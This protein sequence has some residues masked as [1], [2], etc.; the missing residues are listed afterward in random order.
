MF[1]DSAFALRSQRDIAFGLL[2]IGLA[3]ST[4]VGIAQ[5]GSQEKSKAAPTDSLKIG[6]V[7]A[8]FK[9]TKDAM[10][11]GS[12]LIQWI[13]SEQSEGQEMTTTVMT[14]FANVEGLLR[15]ELSGQEAGP[16]PQPADTEQDAIVAST[17]VSDPKTAEDVEAEQI[18]QKFLAPDADLATL[19]LALKP[20]EAACQKLL[21]GEMASRAFQVYSQLFA[22]PKMVLAPRPG[23]TEILLRKIS[24]DEFRSGSEKA[25]AFPGGYRRIAASLNPGFTIYQLSFVKPG[26]TSGMRFDGLVKIDGSWYAFPKVWGLLDEQP[27]GLKIE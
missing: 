26:E 16:S 12:G 13:E 23:Q 9:S 19:T 21:E 4:S 5:D 8:K 10:D 7:G 15:V 11:A 25:T 1:F 20:T 24:T 14:F 27:F 6:T 2:S 22:D 17:R 3:I 18:V